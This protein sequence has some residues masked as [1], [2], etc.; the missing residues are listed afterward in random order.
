MSSRQQ[1]AQPS[2]S[3]CSSIN[4]AFTNSSLFPSQAASNC[5]SVHIAMVATSSS[6]SSQA[7]LQH[8]STKLPD[9]WVCKVNLQRSRE[10]ENVLWSTFIAI[11][12]SQHCQE[13][14][15]DANIY[16]RHF[17]KKK[18]KWSFTSRT[19]R[20]G[21]PKLSSISFTRGTK[22]HSSTKE[23][24]LKHVLFHFRHLEPIEVTKYSELHWH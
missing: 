6:T 12:W 1:T 10:I 7:A 24:K 23:L 4:V 3:P 16:L 19:Q 9:P 11:L 20:S 5:A 14:D 8:L 22:V 13:N 18:E 2:K 17:C 21:T 15:G